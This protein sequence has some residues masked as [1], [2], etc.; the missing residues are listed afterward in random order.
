MQVSEA[1][2]TAEKH[3]VLKWHI[4]RLK[5]TLEEKFRLAAVQV[6]GQAA[7]ASGRY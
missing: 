5:N 4:R 2:R 1:V 3:D 6:R 7:V